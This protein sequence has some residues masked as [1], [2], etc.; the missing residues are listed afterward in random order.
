MGEELLGRQALF[1]ISNEECANEFF[2]RSRSPVWNGGLEVVGA[3]IVT[4]ELLGRGGVKRS[5]PGQTLVDN[6]TNAV[7][8]RL[9]AV[10]MAH[11]H[12]GRHVHRGATQC[13]R[14]VCSLQVTGKAK[15]G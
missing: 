8:V 7:Q 3:F 5:A 10:R 15:V 13:R 4:S 9:S 2:Q 6:R 12:F 11:Q 1:W 14:H